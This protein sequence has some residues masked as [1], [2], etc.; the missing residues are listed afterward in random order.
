ME[1]GALKTVSLNSGLGIA[2]TLGRKPTYGDPFLTLPQ[3]RQPVRLHCKGCSCCQ[4]LGMALVDTP[5]N[6]DNSP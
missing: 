1:G 5:V 4:S 6:L 2:G 3:S